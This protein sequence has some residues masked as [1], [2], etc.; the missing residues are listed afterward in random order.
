M[1]LAC[2]AQRL[3]LL[4]SFSWKLDNES[5]SLCQTDSAQTT[6]CSRGD[7]KQGSK[8]VREMQAKV[9]N[10]FLQKRSQEKRSA[11]YNVFS[12]MREEK[13]LMRSFTNFIP[14]K[15]SKIGQANE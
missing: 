10:P 12:Y 9:N 11:L 8:G 6:S 2:A 7:G 13:C 1:S 5:S 3:V 14:T 15:T 4:M